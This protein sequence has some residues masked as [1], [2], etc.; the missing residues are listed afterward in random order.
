M[1]QLQYRQ[2]GE[3]WF[4]GEQRRYSYNTDSKGKGGVLGN[5]E[6]TVSTPT[7]R[8]EGWCFGEHN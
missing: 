7:V 4:S 8:G 5:R 2:S 6:D 3:G 1:I